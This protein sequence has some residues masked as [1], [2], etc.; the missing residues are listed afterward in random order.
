MKLAT[1]ILQT[2]AWIYARIRPKDP[3][4]LRYEEMMAQS[5]GFE[6]AGNDQMEG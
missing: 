6:L 3:D 1:I 2:Y 5:K 4:L